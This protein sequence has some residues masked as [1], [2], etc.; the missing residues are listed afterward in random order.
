VVRA[1]RGLP[2]AAGR[3]GARHHRRRDDGPRLDL[4]RAA[5]HGVRAAGRDLEPA[6]QVRRGPAR[7][8]AVGGLRG[9][10]RAPAAL[11]ARPHGHE[12]PARA[13]GLLL[14]LSHQAAGVPGA[15]PR[16]VPARRRESGGDDPA[17][18]GADAA[19]GGAVKKDIALYGRVLRYLGPYG[20]LIVA[21]VVATLGFA[22][23]DA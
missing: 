21:A 3:G 8:V 11:P 23:T 4:V 9:E 15:L 16:V 10:R 6:L 22:L 5:G 7:G 2:D 17:H 12:L 19:R 14:R 1:L 18:R 13:R 20:G